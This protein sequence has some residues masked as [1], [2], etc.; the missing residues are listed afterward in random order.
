MNNHNSV[1]HYN[2]DNRIDYSIAL[3]KL[4]VRIENPGAPH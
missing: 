4:Y 1:G 3:I 2:D